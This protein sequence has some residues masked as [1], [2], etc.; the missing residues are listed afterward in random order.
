MPSVSLSLD[1]QG[2]LRFS[3]SDGSPAI[4]LDS[5]DPAVSSPPQALA[6]ATMAC[7]AMDVVYILQKG[8]HDIKSLK[9]VFEGQR[10]EEHPRRFVAMHLRFEITGNPPD[11]AVARAIELSHEKYCSVSNSIR[12]DID[13]KTSFTVST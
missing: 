13:F 5:K 11:E 3:N 4:Q 9:V 10:A 2:D 12:T 8:R 6:Y 7:M 1:W